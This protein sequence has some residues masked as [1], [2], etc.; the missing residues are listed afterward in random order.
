MRVAIDGT[1]ASIKP[2]EK[3][4]MRYEG[5]ALRYLLINGVLENHRMYA[6]TADEWRG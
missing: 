1:V 5:V 2:L 4:G 3:I 6:V